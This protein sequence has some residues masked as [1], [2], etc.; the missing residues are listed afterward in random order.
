MIEKLEQNIGQ[1]GSMS[2]VYSK[3]NELVDHSNRQYEA[4]ITISKCLVFDT[5][6]GLE[7]TVKKILSG[8]H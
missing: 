7:E 4:I 1:L 2:D 8:S 6:I 3:I 5:R